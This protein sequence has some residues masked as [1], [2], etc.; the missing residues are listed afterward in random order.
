MNVPILYLM[1]C[2]K[3]TSTKSPF[4]WVSPPT[5]VPQV[6]SWRVIQ[7]L[8]MSPWSSTPSAAAQKVHI[9]FGNMSRGPSMS[10]AQCHDKCSLKCPTIQKN[11][12]NE[13]GDRPSVM[14]GWW[15]RMLRS[16]DS[17]IYAIT[18]IVLAQAM[19]SDC[20][21]GDLFGIVWSSGIASPLV[22]QGPKVYN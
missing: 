16:L 13:A 1:P 20:W 8:I 19:M 21:P 3:N 17:G 15:T 6:I 9:F 7:H 11:S 5:T 18:A 22:F 14:F 2:L 12:K 4:L 10:G